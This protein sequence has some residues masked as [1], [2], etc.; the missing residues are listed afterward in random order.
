[1]G[2]KDKKGKF[3]K[4]IPVFICISFVVL[5]IVLLKVRSPK[6]ITILYSTDISMDG[7]FDDYF[8]L[9]AIQS[10]DDTDLK[11]I[12][13][14]KDKLQKQSGIKAINNLSVVLNNTNR[15]S[16]VIFG[17]DNNLESIYDADVDNDLIK[18]LE[19]TKDKIDIVTV[20]SLRDIAAL[21][22]S[23]PQLF[24]SKVKRIWVFAGDAEGTMIEYNV[25]LDESAFLR[26]MNSGK[27][28]IY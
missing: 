16:E 5:V 1:M 13:D 12:V 7:D 25:A 4:K 18:I 19:R 22:N 14:G 10:L 8:D 28:D 6:R 11:I 27:C 20:G 2:I 24:E 21:Y 23:S 15:Y 9:V 17:R 3:A 26:I